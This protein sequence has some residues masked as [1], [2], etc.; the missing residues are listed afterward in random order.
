MEMKT[1][2]LSYEKEKAIFAAMKLPER[3]A[4]LT[5]AA[6]TTV[7]AWC[8]DFDRT[9]P[10]NKGVSHGI[11]PTCAAKMNSQATKDGAL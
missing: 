2:F 9:D 11:C 7:C 10:S 1:M 8:P 3:I 6:P 5:D 4:R